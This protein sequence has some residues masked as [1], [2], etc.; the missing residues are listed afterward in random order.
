VPAGEWAP[1]YA[2]RLAAT[3][4]RVLALCSGTR[5]AA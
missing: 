2:R 4:A 3:R 1:I 5:A